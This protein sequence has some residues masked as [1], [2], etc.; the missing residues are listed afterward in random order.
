MIVAA[1]I[2]VFALPS[3]A[4][5]DAEDNFFDRCQE[6]DWSCQTGVAAGLVEGE[7]MTAGTQ[8]AYT[9]ICVDYSG[10]YVY[11]R[12]G[13]KDG[14]PAIGKVESANGIT[15]RLCRNTRGYNTWVRCHFDWA[16]AGNHTAGAGYL[17]DYYRTLH[18]DL[19]WS[20]S[21]K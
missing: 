9:T 8:A 17:E 21:G 13:R 3:A 1:M 5:A 12:D 6:S 2:A 10:D 19:L 18:L 7:C 16:E 15:N 20:W 4:M 11:V 14:Y